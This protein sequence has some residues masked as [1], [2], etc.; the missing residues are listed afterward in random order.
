MMEESDDTNWFTWL[1]IIAVIWLFFFH[2]QKYEGQTAEE[3]F[4]DYDY[5]EAR[6][7]AVK[8]QLGYA[9]D[10]L[11]EINSQSLNYVSGATYEGLQLILLDISIKANRCL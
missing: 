2:K 1:L 5:A 9:E 7:E 4:N 11:D 10:C 8:S 6:L 3:W